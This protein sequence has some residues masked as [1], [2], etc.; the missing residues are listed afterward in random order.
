MTDKQKISLIYFVTGSLFLASGYSLIFKTSHKDAWIAMVIGFILGSIITYFINKYIYIKKENYDKN[1]LNIIL[2]IFYLCIFLINIII[3]RVFTT[4]FYLTKTPG[5]FITIPF[6][7]L[8]IYNIKK[9][10]NVISREAEIL[11]PISFIVILFNL[12]A[13]CKN[14]S[15][16]NFI[17]IYTTSF[18]KLLLSTFYY[19]IF[20]ITPQLLLYNLNIDMKT[21]LKGF[22]FINM[23]IIFIGIV[24][25][26]VLGPN[27]ISVYRFPEYMILKEL[28]L[29]NFIEKIEN[30][31]SLIWF[32]D[33][34]IITSLCLYNV[35]D[36]LEKNNKNKLLYIFIIITLFISEYMAKYYKY[37]MYLYKYMPYILLII[38]IIFILSILIKKKKQQ[39]LF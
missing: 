21:H 28:K 5:L 29:F 27:L 26:F 11:L 39:K 3:L 36:I 2:I 12:V 31:V 33:I 30:L 10:L 22:F 38:S 18:S 1:K 13:V 35:N 7:F 9:G 25:I 32:F 20:T 17:P 14:G 4:S 8:V 34:F 37:V 19:A 6:V 15:I 24:I 23:V 16:S